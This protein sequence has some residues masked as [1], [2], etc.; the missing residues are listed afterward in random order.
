MEYRGKYV[1][2][3]FYLG[4]VTSQDNGKITLT[5]EDD[6][7]IDVSESHECADVKVC[8]DACRRLWEAICARG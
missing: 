4:R 3:R 2:C 7:K 5:M 6:E 8:C 1:G